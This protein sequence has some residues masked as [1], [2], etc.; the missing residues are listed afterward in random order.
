MCGSPS[1]S[2]SDEIDLRDEHVDVV[3]L[4][5]HQPTDQSGC[6]PSTGR[7]EEM[8]RRGTQDDSDNDLDP[9]TE[10]KRCTSEKRREEREGAQPVTS[11]T[12]VIVVRVS[13][14][15][16]RENHRR[17]TMCQSWDRPRLTC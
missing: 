13:A 3:D 15:A 9:R 5:S 16:L 10:L 1:R 14:S 4:G 17:L 6:E 11:G 12:Y 7:R 2:D 8:S